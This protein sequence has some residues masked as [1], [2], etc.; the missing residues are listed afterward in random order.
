M[1]Q[2]VHELKNGIRTPDIEIPVPQGNASKVVIA[3]YSTR[4]SSNLRVM[5]KRNE[6]RVENK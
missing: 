4:N 2:I 3:D 6:N 5:E 1:E